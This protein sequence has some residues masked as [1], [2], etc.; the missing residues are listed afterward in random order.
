MPVWGCSVVS[1]YRLAQAQLNAT[2][3]H[4]GT[5]LA[6]AS[7]TQVEGHVGGL[8]SVAKDLASGLWRCFNST[9]VILCP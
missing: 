5:V 8:P 2:E 3:I 4:L 9:M 6:E 7:T 1:H